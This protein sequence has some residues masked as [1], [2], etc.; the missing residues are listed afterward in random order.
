MHG[1]S[2]SL[3]PACSLRG[4]AAEAKWMKEHAVE[5][6][7]SVALVAALDADSR[8]NSWKLCHPYSC[9][10]LATTL[11]L[12]LVVCILLFPSVVSP[13]CLLKVRVVPPL[14]FPSSA[15]LLLWLAPSGLG[16]ITSQVYCSQSLPSHNK[17]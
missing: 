4:L 11:M 7:A 6:K 1:L 16:N 3:S 9:G 5:E 13:K 17:P 8:W 15:D 14:C 12:L 10:F 2:S